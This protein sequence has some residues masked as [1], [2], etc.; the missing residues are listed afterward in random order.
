[1][2]TAVHASSG[3]NGRSRQMARTPPA[4]HSHSVGGATGAKPRFG[5]VVSHRNRRSQ[6]TRPRP[7]VP[8]K[9]LSRCASLAGR[10]DGSGDAVGVPREREERQQ[11]GDGEGALAPRQAAAA[12]GHGRQHHGDDQHAVRP[13]D[14]GERGEDGGQRRAAAALG[15]ERAGDEREQERH[16]AAERDEQQRA[17]R[18]EQAGGDTG[19]ATAR[20]R[21]GRTSSAPAP[22]AGSIR[23]VANIDAHERTPDMAGMRSGP[24]SQ[25]SA[26]RIRP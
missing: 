23:P 8:H 9:P 17:G 24:N 19:A 18:V 10:V 26:A 11:H 14:G 16:L 4:I 3:R 12:N 2:N 6:S 5:R 21:A 22:S 1:M 7:N 13:R 20:R 25:P 15:Q